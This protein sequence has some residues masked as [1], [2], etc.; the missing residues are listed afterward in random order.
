MKCFA[1]RLVEEFTRDYFCVD[2]VSIGDPVF[3]YGDE[4]GMNSCSSVNKKRGHFL[5]I[6]LYNVKNIDLMTRQPRFNEVS[7]GS[8]IEIMTRG[9]LVYQLNKDWRIPMG[10]KVYYCPKNKEI[11]WRKT[12][13][14]I[15]KAISN[16][17]YDGYIKVKVKC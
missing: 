14:K 17:N 15:G 4:N 11:T 1:N 9:W 8:K 7:C 3:D 16:Q 6:S 2:P 5:G 10:Q 12:D 13:I